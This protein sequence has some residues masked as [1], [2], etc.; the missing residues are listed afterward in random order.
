VEVEDVGRKDYSK[1]LMVF[2]THRKVPRR[3]PHGAVTHPP[4]RCRAWKM[5]TSW[6]LVHFPETL[7]STQSNY[8]HQIL[9]PFHPA[10]SAIQGLCTLLWSLIL[11]DFLHCYLLLQ[12]LLGHKQPPSKIKKDQRTQCTATPTDPYPPQSTL[13]PYAFHARVVMYTLYPI[14]SQSKLEVDSLARRTSH[15]VGIPCI[16]NT[17]NIGPAASIWW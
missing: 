6:K 3:R 8:L 11:L 12:A 9:Q 1:Q 16:R 4:S 14:P 2:L 17:H 10:H 7:L 5:L 15:D 13:K